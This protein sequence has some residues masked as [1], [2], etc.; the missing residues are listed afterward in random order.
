MNNRDP[1]KAPLSPAMVVGP[2][3][4]IRAVYTTNR[5]VLLQNGGNSDKSNPS[6]RQ[7]ERAPEHLARA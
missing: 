2:I 4:T 6:G 5:N 3:P 1:T 7:A